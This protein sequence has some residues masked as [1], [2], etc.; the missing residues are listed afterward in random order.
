MRKSALESSHGFFLLPTCK[1]R[2]GQLRTL[3]ESS[4]DKFNQKY[5]E[6]FFKEYLQ[7]LNDYQELL[8]QT[9]PA[10]RRLSGTEDQQLANQILDYLPKE[11]FNENN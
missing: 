10:Y 1:K 11:L 6:P 8:S 7:S 2:F 9:S 4:T 3:A 5:Y